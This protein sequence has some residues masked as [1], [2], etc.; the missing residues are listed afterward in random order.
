MTGCVNDRHG[1]TTTLVDWGFVVLV[2]W[3]LG[4][5]LENEQASIVSSLVVQQ[6]TGL[7][8]ARYQSVLMR[9]QLS[10]KHNTLSL[11]PGTGWRCPGVSAATLVRSMLTQRRR[12]LFNNTDSGQQGH[13]PTRKVVLKSEGTL[14]KSLGPPTLPG[15]TARAELGRLPGQTEFCTSRVSA[16]PGQSRVDCQGRVSLH[17]LCRGRLP[18]QS[19][20]DCQGRVNFALAELVHCPRRVG[21][22][23]KQSWCTARAELVYTNSAEAVCQGSLPGQNKFTLTLPGQ[24]VYTTSASALPE[25]S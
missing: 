1:H 9:I 5:L 15:Q 14:H 21:A 8:N 10:V 23:P 20:A 12:S 2:C 4:E 19:W 17:Q 6:T 16:L 13:R 3:R 11:V 7:N 18:G 22:L 25:Q 24:L